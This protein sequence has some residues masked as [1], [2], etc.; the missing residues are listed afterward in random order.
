MSMLS[1]HIPT[2][3]FLKNYVVPFSFLD[4]RAP[5]AFVHMH[6]QPTNQPKK[7]LMVYFLAE[8]NSND[9]I[10]TREDGIRFLGKKHG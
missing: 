5:I 8:S 4:T 6:V 10:K 7:K 3:L 2:T 9:E 1:T